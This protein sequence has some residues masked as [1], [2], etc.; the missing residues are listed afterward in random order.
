MKKYNDKKNKINYQNNKEKY[1][2]KGIIYYQENKEKIKNRVKKY[3][4]NNKEKIRENKRVYILN[5]RKNDHKSFL[6][7]KTKW[8]LNGFEYYFN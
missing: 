3:C 7:L 2:E 4:E 5:R 1:S 8:W 6:E